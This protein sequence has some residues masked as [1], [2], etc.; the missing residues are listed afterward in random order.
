M[1]PTAQRALTLLA[2]GI[3][4]SQVAS[5]LGITESAV[6]QYASDEQF[7]A[8]LAELRFEKLRKHNARDSELD[9]LEDSLIKQLK[10]FIPLAVRPMEIA[11]I[12]QVVNAA[13]RRGA[14]APQ[15]I[16]MSQPIIK[17]SIPSMVINNVAVKVDVNNQ[18]LSTADQSLVT[19]PSNQIQKLADTLLPA[20]GAR[21]EPRNQK[22]ITASDLGFA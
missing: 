16:S 9:A 11:R 18:V 13:K 14:S 7:A 5:T 10:Q 3:P 19:I 20:P 17:L 6:S 1:N 4:A 12:L 21:N 8:K 15:E 22:Q 2:D